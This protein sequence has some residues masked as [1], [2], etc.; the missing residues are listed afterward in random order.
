M[1]REKSG[2]RLPPVVE[3][4][5]GETRRVGF[6]L[7][8]SGISLPQAIDAVKSSLGA[9]TRDETVA[10]TT[11]QVESLGEFKVELDWAYLKRKAREQGEDPETQEWLERLGRAAALLV[12]VEVV[13]PPIPVTQLDRL[14][15]H[16]KGRS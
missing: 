5:R 8:F 10:D 15:P 11:L 2:Y 6:E 12:P 7:E 13:C 14:D 1:T 16:P 4:E 3:T 9:E